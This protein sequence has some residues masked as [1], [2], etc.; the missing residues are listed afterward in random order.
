[1]R[2]VRA[3]ASVSALGVPLIGKRRRRRQMSDKVVVCSAYSIVTP[4][5]LESKGTL[6][7]FTLDGATMSFPLASDA[8]T[9]QEVSAD[10]LTLTAARISSGSR[11]TPRAR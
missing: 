5:F 7:W 11:R 9:V 1:A 6:L 2:T 10:F 4:E 8:A 3:A